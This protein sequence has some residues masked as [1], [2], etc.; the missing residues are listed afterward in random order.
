MFTRPEM[1]APLLD[2]PLGPVADIELPPPHAAVE[3]ANAATR[4][5]C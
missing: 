4:I 1:M 5:Q 3:A 2:T